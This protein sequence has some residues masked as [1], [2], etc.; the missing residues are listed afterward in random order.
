MSIGK[1]IE[2]VRKRAKLTQEAFADRLGFSR[3]SL[4]TWEKDLTPPPVVAV[5]KLR[6]AFDIDPEWVIMGEGLTPCRHFHPID[7][8]VYD[9]TIREIEKIAREVRLVLTREQTERL[10]RIEFA[11]GTLMT[12]KDRSR[13]TEYLRALSLE[14]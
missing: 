8:D 13:L 14:R 11:N 12:G 2:A 5:V 6:E 9:E 4:H 3:R 1:R 10:A 7:W